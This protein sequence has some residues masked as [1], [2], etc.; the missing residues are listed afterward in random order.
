MDNFWYKEV[1]YASSRKDF[2]IPCLTVKL[3]R[4]VYFI[5]IH[6]KKLAKFLRKPVFF[7]CNLSRTGFC[8]LIN[9]KL[10]YMKYFIYLAKFIEYFSVRYF[11][12]VPK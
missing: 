7:A 12:L 2:A 3:V 11:Y 4:H 10:I 6:K 9:H 1:C 5:T 8:V